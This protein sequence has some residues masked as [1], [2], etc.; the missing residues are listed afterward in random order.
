MT[1]LGLRDKLAAEIVYV[2]YVCSWCGQRIAVFRS[3]DP[4]KSPVQEIVSK[5][6]C[7]RTRRIHLDEI[8]SLEVWK[9][10]GSRS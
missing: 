4:P 1:S 6:K 7:G 2:G 9:E 8:Q 10:S 5:C 3:S